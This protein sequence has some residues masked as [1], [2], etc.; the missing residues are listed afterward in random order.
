[1]LPDK[2]TNAT[3]LRDCFE[4]A[5]RGLISHCGTSDGDIINVGDRVLGKLRLK[6]VRHVV[7]EDG[8]RVSPT[9]REFGETEGAV[10]GLE[11][12]VVAGHFSESAFI[13]SD[14]QVEHPS[15][16]TTCEVL[17]DLFS[18]GS[19]A[20][21]L[22]CDGVERFEAVDRA[23]G[24]GFF[25]HYAEPARAVR[26]VQALV[27]TGIHLCPNNFANLI[28]DTRRYRNVS[29]N[30]GGMC[31]DGNFDRREEVLAEVTALGVVPSEPFVLERHEMV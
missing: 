25:L 3:V 7:V 23:N 4:G 12:G 18:E 19:D 24:I 31:D 9:H 13:V 11:S 8:D 17:G 6:D 29:L 15:A 2:V 26:G 10:W 14:I 28:V 16:G 27:Y 1:M 20:G 22:D 5:V 21:V 30:P